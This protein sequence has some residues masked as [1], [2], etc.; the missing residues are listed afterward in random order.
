MNDDAEWEDWTRQW[1]E[2][3]LATTAPDLRTVRPRGELLPAAAIFLA[4]L[5]AAWGDLHYAHSTAGAAGWLMLFVLLIALR[6]FERSAASSAGQTTTQYRRSLVS[7]S[8]MTLA[9]GSLGTSASLVI[10]GRWAGHLLR[11]GDSTASF[12]AA[13]LMV[14]AACGLV[15][16]SKKVLESARMLRQ[17]TIFRRQAAGTGNDAATSA[18]IAGVIAQRLVGKHRKRRGQRRD[19]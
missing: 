14:L 6:R 16:F 11:A 5:A 10:A 8:R 19:A 13:G 9:L 4:C 2:Q 7:G 15:F 1:R 17:M 3:A 18:G 12:G